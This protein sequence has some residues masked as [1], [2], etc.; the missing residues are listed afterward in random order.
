MALHH[1]V[2][3]EAE[4]T[5][6]LHLRALDPVIAEKA[7]KIPLLKELFFKFLDGKKGVFALDH[8][9]FNQVIELALSYFPTYEI[10]YEIDELFQALGGELAA[11]F[12]SLSKDELKR[13]LELS[14]HFELYRDA[15]GAWRVK[16]CPSG[17][18]SLSSSI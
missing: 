4:L 8:S 11:Q 10:T 1:G 14:S 16:S 9:K 17:L 7:L 6:V 12:Q 5:E 13:F 15:L 18:F 2:G 3:S